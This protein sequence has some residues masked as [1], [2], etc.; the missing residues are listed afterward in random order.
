MRDKLQK[1][2]KNHIHHSISR[3]NCQLVNWYSVKLDSG[4]I[5]NHKLMYLIAKLEFRVHILNIP[6]IYVK[7]LQKIH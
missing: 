5:T 4:W 1:K 6:I 2:K 3:L 7:K